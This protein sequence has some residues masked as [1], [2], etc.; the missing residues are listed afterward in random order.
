AGDRDLSTPLVWA[1]AEA[2]HAP[3]G[4]LVIVRGAGHGG[5]LRAHNPVARDAVARFLQ[6]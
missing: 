5:Q 2:R 1:Q 3:R 4:R 6:G